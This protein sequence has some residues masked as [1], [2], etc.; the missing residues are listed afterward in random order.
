M[1]L[2]SKCCILKIIKE[3]GGGGGGSAITESPKVEITKCHMPLKTWWKAI[4]HSS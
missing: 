1:I 3:G 4:L 2:A